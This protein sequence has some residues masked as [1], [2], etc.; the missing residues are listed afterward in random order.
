MPY[1]RLDFFLCRI[2]WKISI[3]API[4]SSPLP[5]LSS[6]ETFAG[7]ELYQSSFHWMPS[8]YLL[9]FFFNCST[10]SILIYN[11]IT[12]IPFIHILCFRGLHSFFSYLR[13]TA[14][15]IIFFSSTFFLFPLWLHTSIYWH[16]R[17][18]FLDYYLQV[19]QLPSIELC[20][21]F[22]NH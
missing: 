4:Q 22:F 5:R 10:Y 19:D 2:S 13:M 14:Y 7:Q 9:S 3:N 15:S 17:K 11:L 1:N 21:S 20:A 12:F 8:S 18:Y 16:V 6:S